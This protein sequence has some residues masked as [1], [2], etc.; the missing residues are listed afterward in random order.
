MRFFTLFML[1]VPVLLNA[2]EL[3]PN[4]D[5][6]QLAG[7]WVRHWSPARGWK[8]KT[9]Y[10]CSKGLL[11]I[12]RME[13]GSGAFL[14]SKIPVE[15][16]K[17]YT[18]SIRWR[19]TIE[20]GIADLALYWYDAN[21]RNLKY[22]LVK[23]MKKS[24]DITDFAGKVTAPDKAAS[25]QMLLV[26]SG[27]GNAEFFKAGFTGG[28]EV[29]SS[30]S[31]KPDMEGNCAPNADF[32]LRKGK[33]PASWLPAVNWKGKSEYGMTADGL[34]YI[35]RSDRNGSGAYIATFPVKGETFYTVKA[36]LKSEKLSGIADVALQFVD[37]KGKI[38]NY[39][40]I[41]RI[42]KETDWKT[43][44]KVIQTPA[45]ALKVRFLLIIGGEG[46]VTFRNPYFGERIPDSAAGKTAVNLLLNPSFE[47]ADFQDDFTDSWQLISGKARRTAGA[48]HGFHALELTP[49]AKIRYGWEAP[50]V[51][52]SG[53]PFLYRRISACGTGKAQFEL[54]FY[55]A[56]GKKIAASTLEIA[57]EGKAYQSKTDKVNI[58]AGAVTAAVI[59]ANTGSGTVRIDGLYLGENPFESH[60]LGRSIPIV[61][62]PETSAPLTMP[63]NSIRDH[64]GIPTWFI[65]DTPVVNSTF[66]S[67]T[68]STMRP[69]WYDYGKRV[70]RSGKFPILVIGASISPHD[71][72]ERHTLEKA[73]A[74]TEFSI[75]AALAE[76]PD[77]RFV[78][79]LFVEPTFTFAAR[80]PDEIIKKEDASLKWASPEPPYSYGSEIWG[81]LCSRRIKEYLHALRKKPFADRIVGISPGLGKYAENNHAHANTVGGYTAGGFCVAMTNF[82]RQWL[83][84]EYKGDVTAFAKA[85]NRKGNFNFTNALVPSSLQ[86]LQKLGGAFYDPAKQRQVI[87]YNR[88]S[89]FAILHRV[90]KLCRSAKEATGNRIFTFAQFAYFTGSMN[91]RELAVAL[92]S[93]HLDA[94]GPAPPYINRGPGDDIPDHGPAA[95]VREHNKVWLC[96]A[97]VRSHLASEHNWMYG[98]THNEAESIAVYLRETG[99]YMTAGIIPYHMTFERWYDTPAL[100]KLVGNFDRWM[101]LS[102]HFSRKSAAEVAVVMDPVSLSVGNETSYVRRI[103]PPFQSSLE[104]NR[105]FEWHHLGAPYDFFMLDDLLRS[106]RLD[107]YKAVIM[108]AN[109]SIS[110]E[111][112]QLIEKR[113]KRNGRTIIWIYAPGFFNHDKNLLTCAVENTGITGF[114]LAVD[115]K[116]HDLAIK[117]AGGKLYGRFTTDIYGGFTIPKRP[118]KVR[119]ETFRPRFRVIPG[120]DVKIFGTYAEDNAPAAAIRKF[121]DHTSVFWGSTA[122]NK[123][124]LRPILEKAGVH[125]Y[126]PLPAVVYANGNFLT[127]HSPVA[128]KRVIRLPYKAELIYDLYAEK[129]LAADSDSVTVD[130]AKNSSVLLY[131]GGRDRFRKALN[132]VDSAREAREKRNAPKRTVFKFGAVK[133]E[134]LAKRAATGTLYPVEDTGFIRHWQILGP[135][136]NSEDAKAFN[137]DFLN[138]E[139]N[140]TVKTDAVYHAVFDA[141]GNKR[142]LEK[143]LWFNGKA[144]KR[145]L[146]LKWMPFE[147]SQ[148][149]VVPLSDQIGEFP[150]FDRIAYYVFC[151]VISDKERQLIL[152]IGSDDGHKSW[153]NGEL[154]TSVNVMSRSAQPDTDQGK[155]TLKKGENTLLLKVCQGQGKL[156]HIVRFLEPEN[157][158]PVTDLKISL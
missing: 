104:Y 5:F 86:R 51:A 105:T 89:S 2:L 16:G 111:N 60:R 77:A 142:A 21:G 91:H 84:Q 14:S 29:K 45:T 145:T 31:N 3:A 129:E 39:Q 56:G 15:A 64:Q 146:Q 11:C 127:V 110:A 38:F 82:F 95:S 101:A 88:C 121:K 43:F 27:V 134:P 81:R 4:G 28:D 44:Q 112:R 61:T 125:F 137:I 154:I 54:T 78:I 20:K 158:R 132:A 135:F 99:H 96:Q 148:G 116:L 34:P 46:K 128:G 85:W 69:E 73:L 141:S 24:F 35:S 33:L 7:K 147:F 65:G 10:R 55:N 79:W 17:E 92:R 68:S 140:R 120:K 149:I 93:P 126:T 119:P 19:A 102:G 58:P 13:P 49:G 59:I 47:E 53:F 9:D 124:V 41:G 133:K 67:S 76:T 8:G 136:P 156:G 130:M 72:G 70:L 150:F 25:V 83:F 155:V 1:A 107:Q 63:Q 80:F 100:M 106:P 90:L 131:F 40:L 32:K 42:K 144:E 62:D 151:K 23:R 52:V 22:T 103:M 71:R 138:G 152:A 26:L 18:A 87:D 75:K 109:Y 157:N 50:A 115:N 36:D 66:T 123:E 57:P 113:L 139:K 117:T 114:D 143:S 118:V 30:D 12:E 108:A 122:L 48:S 37:A 74:K 98:R 97:D 94:L 6:Q 153:F